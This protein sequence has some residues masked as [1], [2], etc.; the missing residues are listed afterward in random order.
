[1]RMQSSCAQRMLLVMQSPWLTL[2]SWALASTPLSSSLHLSSAARRLDCACR[3]QTWWQLCRRVPTFEHNHHHH[4]HMGSATSQEAGTSWLVSASCA[5]L[6]SPV[7]CFQ[8][9][10]HVC[11]TLNVYRPGASSNVNA[12]P[13]R[14]VHAHCMALFKDDPLTSRS[15]RSRSAWDLMPLSADSQDCIATQALGCICRRTSTITSSPLKGKMLHLHNAYTYE[16]KGAAHGLQR[17]QRA[18]G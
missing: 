13:A 12:S 2:R 4:S 9:T 18:D 8:R 17:I 7:H 14:Y 11:Y 1:M 6:S 10:M 3:E 5:P 15:R 16:V